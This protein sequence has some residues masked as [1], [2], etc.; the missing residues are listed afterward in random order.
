M[1]LAALLAS[2]SL[3]GYAETAE[4]LASGTTYRRVDRAR[5]TEQSKRVVIRFLAFSFLS[6]GQTAVCGAEIVINVMQFGHTR[7]YQRSGRMTDSVLE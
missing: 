3:N 2:V 7:N 4:L 6:V 5:K 1:Q